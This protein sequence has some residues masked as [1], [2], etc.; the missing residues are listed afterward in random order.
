MIIDFHTHIFPDRVAS[1][2]LSAILSCMKVRYTPVTDGTKAGLLKNMDD[3]GIDISV[4]QPVITKQSQ[5]RSTNLWAREICS[6]RI[7]SFGG[8]YP[9]TE[10]YK[11]EIDFVV[12]LGLKGLKFHSDNQGF[13]IDDPRMLRIY[14]YAL[15]RG[16]ILLFHAGFDPR[17]P[18]PFRSSPRQF[19]NVV[20]AMRGGVI[21]AAHLGGHAQWDDVEK[22]LVGEKIYLDTSMGLEYYP[23]EQFLRIVR[24]HGADKILFATDSPWSSGKKEL[25]TLNALPL[26]EQEREMILGLNAKKLLGLS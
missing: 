8:I 26:N 13:A 24:A 3:W 20:H 19:A 21:V 16:L 2:A 9:Y 22:Y 18:A 11:S 15:S 12:D 25:E 23:H 10:D 14:D 7:I 17:F 5:S 1:R 6:D 4:V